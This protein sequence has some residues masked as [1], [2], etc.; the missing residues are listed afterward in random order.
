MRLLVEPRKR[1]TVSRKSG[2][3][4]IFRTM[5]H[6]FRAGG[7]MGA[8]EEAHRGGVLHRPGRQPADRLR[9]PQRR[10]RMFHAVPFDDT[11]TAKVLAFT[12]A[13]LTAGVTGRK[14]A[15]LELTAVVEPLLGSA[16][17]RVRV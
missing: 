17:W 6:P 8:D 4:A 3:Q 1:E 13:R 12:V 5:R 2:R 10:V 14:G 16:G 7:R 11:E 9:V 15:E